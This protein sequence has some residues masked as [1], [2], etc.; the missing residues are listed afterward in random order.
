M[1]I[2]LDKII[3]EAAKQGAEFVTDPKVEDSL[4]ELLAARDKLIESV[5]YVEQQIASALTTENPINRSVTGKRVRFSMRTYGPKYKLDTEKAEPT[6]F[7]YGKPRAYPKTKEIDQFV[8]NYG[9]LPVGVE[10]SV[11]ELKAKL[12]VID[13]KT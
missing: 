13:E 9:Q 7:Y 12:E 11:R 2:D 6:L 5:A 3:S 1:T 10:E 8:E 4:L